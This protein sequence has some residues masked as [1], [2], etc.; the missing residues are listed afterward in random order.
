MFNV[1]IQQFS[2]NLPLWEIKEKTPHQRLAALFSAKDLLIVLKHGQPPYRVVLGVPHQAPIGV[3]RI[4]EQRLDG[5]GN[6]KP[7]KADDNVVSFALVAFSRLRAC[8]IPSKLVI[9]VHSTTHDPNKILDSPYCREVFSEG[10]KLLFECH[11]SGGRRHLDLELSAGSNLLGRPFE[12]GRQLAAQFEYRYSLG[13]QTAAKKT[14]ALIIQPNG[15]TGTGRLQLPAIKTTSLTEA[16]RRSIP[17]LH[18]EAKPRFR[19]PKDLTN[20]VSPDGLILG[21]ALADTL[22]DLI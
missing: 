4:C 9:M 21:R 14:T 20:A 5:S 10:M 6:P 3:T 11:A 18:L 17:A 19:I 13:L 2:Q 16:G 15:S 1:E 22:C 8:D 12:F 7:R